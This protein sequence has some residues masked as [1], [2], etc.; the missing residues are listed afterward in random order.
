MTFLFVKPTKETET[1]NRNGKYST[2]F[3]YMKELSLIFELFVNI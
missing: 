1:R 2:S 3:F